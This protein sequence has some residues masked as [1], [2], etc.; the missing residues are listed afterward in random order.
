M[1]A[2][3]SHLESVGH[4]RMKGDDV[5]FTPKADISSVFYRPQRPERPQLPRRGEA[6]SWIVEGDDWRVL[7]F[8]AVSAR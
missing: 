4:I 3:R 2:A 7:S 8:R 1:L 5:R 6:L